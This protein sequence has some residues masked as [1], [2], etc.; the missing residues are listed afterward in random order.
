M[1]PTIEKLEQASRRAP[2]P[3]GWKLVPDE[4]TKEMIQRACS[5]HGFPGGSRWVYRDGYKSML[6][7]TPQPPE[8]EQCQS[9]RTGSP[10]ACTCPFKT[11]RNSDP[12]CFD[13]APVQMPEPFAVKHY[14]GCD[15][16][17][18]KGNG[19]DGLEIGE[20]REEAENFVDWVNDRIAAQALLMPSLL[21]TSTQ[22]SK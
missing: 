8:A 19:F 22:S 5:D 2:V 4:P 9:C 15:R 18:I 1:S 20:D 10:Y 17:I 21:K 12:S 3:Q 16:P 6:A 13:E 14:T 11:A 7:A